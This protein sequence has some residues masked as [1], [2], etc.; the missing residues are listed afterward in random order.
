M[1]SRIT[2]VAVLS[3][4]AAGCAT[5]EAPP[6]SAP[7]GALTGYELVSLMSGATLSGN[8]TSTA[9]AT[10]TQ[11][12]QEIPI[13][14]SKGKAEGTWNPPGAAPS[15]YKFS[16]RLKGDQWCEKWDTGSSCWH[17]VPVSGTDYQ[18]Y[19]DGAPL[20]EIWKIDSPD[21]GPL[22]LTPEQIKTELTNNQVNSGTWQYAGAGGNESGTF[23]SHLCAD[24]TR[25]AS[26]DDKPFDKSNWFFEGD[27]MCN[28]LPGKKRCYG[29][30]KH[31][32]GSF[33][34]FRRT[35]SGQVTSQST[36]QGP[37]DQCNA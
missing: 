21:P 26:S 30:W 27:K 11:T 12:Y 10:F 20:S 2:P 17:V 3:I 35:E 15:S 8:S 22:R 14:K 24:G 13:R 16:W 32:D 31:P 23:V 7:V 4:L 1:F 37:S 18:F 25:Y 5:T 9:G 36:V 6:V 34:T 29:I 19:K 28:Q 33:S